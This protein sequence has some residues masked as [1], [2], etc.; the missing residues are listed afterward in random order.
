VEDTSFALSL[1]AS[2]GEYGCFN[3][4]IS[5]SKPRARHSLLKELIWQGKQKLYHRIAE[6]CTILLV[7]RTSNLCARH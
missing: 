4:Q 2:G 1:D 7:N 6:K 5:S 3:E